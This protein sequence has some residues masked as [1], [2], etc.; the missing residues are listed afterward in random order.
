MRLPIGRCTKG[1][2]YDWTFDETKN[3]WYCS[4]CEGN[5][6]EITEEEIDQWIADCLADYDDATEQV[7]LTKAMPNDGEAE[8]IMYLAKLRRAEKH[9]AEASLRADAASMI[10][11][12]RNGN[13][14]GKIN[15]NLPDINFQVNLQW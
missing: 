4:N 6:V 14:T 3:T 1:C 7:V 5:D 9:L 12:L 11:I 13:S 15:I 2:P 8:K 10:E